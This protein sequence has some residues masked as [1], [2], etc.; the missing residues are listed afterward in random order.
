M[1]VVLAHSVAGDE[2]ALEAR[3]C[4]VEALGGTGR[5]PSGPVITTL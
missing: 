4:A 5:Y 3:L 2:T 1:H